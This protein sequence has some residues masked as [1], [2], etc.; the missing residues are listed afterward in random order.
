[1][2]KEF[3][4]IACPNGCRLKVDDNPSGYKVE[5]YTCEKG[6]EYAIQ[7]VEDPRRIITSTVRIENGFLALLPVKT[8]KPIPK[9]LIFDVMKEINKV[10]VKAPIHLGDIIIKNIISTGIDVIATRDMLE[11][12]V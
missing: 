7:E 11:E 9:D 12:K 1:M 3:I 6:K 4:C 2:H 5:G 8:A 10:R